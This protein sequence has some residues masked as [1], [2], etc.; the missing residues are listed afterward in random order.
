MAARRF[1]KSIGLAYDIW[2]KANK[3]EYLGLALTIFGDRLM[4]GQQ[5]LVLFIGVRIPIPEPRKIKQKTVQNWTVFC[6]HTR[7]S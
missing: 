5:V 4:V 2:S 7:R 1:D 6:F 3:N